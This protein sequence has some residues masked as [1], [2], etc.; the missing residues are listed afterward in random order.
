[1]SARICKFKLDVNS[2]VEIEMPQGARVLHVGAQQGNVMLWAV[3]DLGKP[4]EHR[5]FRVLGTG[6]E[7]PS[8]HLGYLGTAFIDVFVWHVFEEVS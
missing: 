3:A 1:M 5:R 2:V 8:T 4:T 6:M 7:L